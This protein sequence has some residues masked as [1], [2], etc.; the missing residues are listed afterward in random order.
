MLT[1]NQLSCFDTFGFIHLKQL[2]SSEEITT[3]TQIAESIWIEELGYK[4]ALEEE[5]G[6]TPFIERHPLLIAY[7]LEDD[8]LYN[9]FVQLMGEDFI[10]SGSEGNRGFTKE[11]RAH[12]WHADRPGP[13][14]LDYLRIKV[15][16]YLDP[17]QKAQ[18][19]LRVIP[20]SHRLPLHAKLESFQTSH[21]TKNP[22]FFGMDGAAIPCHALETNPGDVVL[23][24]HS[25]FH[26]V[27]GKSGQRR[28]IALKFAC[29]PTCQNHLASLQQWSPYAF[30]PDKRL[31][32]NN[33]PQLRRMV[34]GVE[35]LGQQAASL[36]Y[37][38]Y[39]T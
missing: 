20:G 12:H 15:M 36:A 7:M 39:T 22:T 14:E 18:G 31:L 19:A 38:P 1:H 16:I 17:M 34:A 33:N 6:I 3:I 25:L 5:L 28:Y 32:N 13:F 37:P 8:R 11:F 26:S 23:F 21:S 35:A 9:A 30:K 10:W 24:N 29:Q 2:F 27:Y 4:P